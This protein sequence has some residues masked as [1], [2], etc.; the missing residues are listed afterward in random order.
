MRER[1]VAD[2]VGKEELEDEEEERKRKGEEQEEVRRSC[3]SGVGY[4]RLRS[5]GKLW[6]HSATAGDCSGSGL[7]LRSQVTREVATR[8]LSAAEMREADLV[9]FLSRRALKLSLLDDF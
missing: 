9:P 6:P 4:L 5:I 3:S 8:S 1:G 7:W 2:E